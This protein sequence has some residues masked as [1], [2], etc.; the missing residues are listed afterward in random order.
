MVLADKNHLDN[1]LERI[2][3]IN[4][5]STLLYITWVAL[6][7]LVGLLII[8][9]LLTIYTSAIKQRGTKARRELARSTVLDI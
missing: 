4:G 1:L 5:L 6:G 7:P 8:T 3:M 9:T 2:R